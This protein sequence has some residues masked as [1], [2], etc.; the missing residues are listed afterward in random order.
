[1][2]GFKV[3]HCLVF[4]LCVLSS[5]ISAAQE[6]VISSEASY[7]T[8]Q[9]PGSLGTYPMGINNSMAVTGYYYVTPM[10]TRG[11]LRNPDGTITT[12]DVP[13]GV[14]TE[15]VSINA[16]GDVTGIGLVGNISFGFMRYADGRVVTFED[17]LAAPGTQRLSDLLK[18][19]LS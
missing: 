10:V 9:V 3:R 12:F 8:F 19:G 6:P 18:D 15:P 2:C 13:G 17:F 16:A 14:S 11:F 4:T 7:L 5:L 1:M